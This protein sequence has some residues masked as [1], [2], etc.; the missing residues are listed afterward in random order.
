MI[1]H[2]V[3]EA[4]QARTRTPRSVMS[5]RNWSLLRNPP[6]PLSYCACAQTK[7]GPLVCGQPHVLQIVDNK[8]KRR[9]TT[10]TG[11][12]PT[13]LKMSW[14]CLSRS[15]ACGMQEAAVSCVVLAALPGTVPAHTACS[16]Q[17]CP[18]GPQA[19]HPHITLSL[20][21]MPTQPSCLWAPL[22]ACRDF[23]SGRPQ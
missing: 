9:S 13:W 3:I 15:A 12:V 20:W 6:R 2:H 18:D 14:Y 23:L 8:R 1:E 11:N 4:K 22:H 7:L 17:L 10:G 21:L 19:W 16:L 5:A